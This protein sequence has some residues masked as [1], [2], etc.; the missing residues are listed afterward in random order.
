[1]E[2]PSSVKTK[3]TIALLF[4]VIPAT[5]KEQ[6]FRVFGPTG[7]TLIVTCKA[8]VQKI[9][10][11]D[12]EGTKQEAHDSGYCFG[13]VS[14]VAEHLNE[15]DGVDFSLWRQERRKRGAEE[16]TPW[17]G[18]CTYKLFW[19]NE[20][21]PACT[22]NTNETITTISAA[23]ITGVSHKVDHAPLH[24]TP[25]SCPVPSSENQDF[26]LIPKD[27]AAK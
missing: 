2:R 9:D 16:T 21:T 18:D 3:L 10:N 15:D 13:F 17:T 22:V 23:E 26:S 25:S 20:T 27:Q 7:N 12:W 8:A 14:T 19:N 6:W 4:L 11:P 24:Q 1:V 5:A